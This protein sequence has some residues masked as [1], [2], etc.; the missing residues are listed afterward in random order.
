MSHSNTYGPEDSKSSGSDEDERNGVEVTIRRY[1]SDPSGEPVGDGTGRSV[2]DV[3]APSDIFD[4][5]DE[6]RSAQRADPRVEVKQRTETYHAVAVGEFDS[7]N[8]HVPGGMVRLALADGR[9][10]SVE[11]AEIIAEGGSE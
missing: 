5:P 11:N 4:E 8:E 2:R 9:T 3:L 6:W 7:I 10:V 1:K